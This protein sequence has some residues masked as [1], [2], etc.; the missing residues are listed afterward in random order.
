MPGV[1]ETVR[2]DFRC[3]AEDA[4]DAV[5]DAIYD[6]LGSP[7]VYQYDRGRLSS[8][9][10]RI[11]KRRYIDTWRSRAAEAGRE[12]K[13]ADVV[14]LRSP[15]PKETMEHAAEA[16]QLWDKVEHIVTDTRDREALLLL[17]DGERS[18]GA[19]AEVLGLSGLP[20]LQQQ[21]E[22]KRH[23]D[24]L[25]KILSRLGDKLNDFRT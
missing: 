11:A 15:A 21:R 12:K 19:L 24:R 18:T 6:Y 5:I 10:I 2:R 25:L 3:S 17:L 8:F 16:R 13:F 14:E 4:H 9:L 23:R 22:V 7:E 20:E 1:T